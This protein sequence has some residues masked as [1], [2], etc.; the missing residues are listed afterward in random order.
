M[1]FAFVSWWRG[2]GSDWANRG[3]V[4]ERPNS[5][6]GA[7]AERAASH[8]Q[9]SRPLPCPRLKRQ[10]LRHPDVCRSRYRFS[11]GH[12]NSLEPWRCD[13]ALSASAPAFEWGLSVFRPRFAQS[14]P[15]PRQ[16]ETNAKLIEVGLQL[17]FD[18]S[19]DSN[20]VSIQPR[21]AETLES[22]SGLCCRETALCRLTRW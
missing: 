20:Q 1:S 22:P 17:A 7:D 2:H 13:A 16:H 5:K 19:D 14:L 10:W 4:S 15:W 3:R 18:A 12:G 11:L 6:A 8:R 9:G 21:D